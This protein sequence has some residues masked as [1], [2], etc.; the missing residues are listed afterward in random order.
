MDSNTKQDLIN[1]YKKD[2]NGYRKVKFNLIREGIINADDLEEIK[3]IIKDLEDKKKKNIRIT[4]GVGT[5]VVFASFMLL[6]AKMTKEIDVSAHDIDV[7]KY[8]HQISIAPTMQVLPNQVVEITSTPT[9]TIIPT[10]VLVEENYGF[11]EEIKNNENCTVVGKKCKQTLDRLSDEKLSV[12]VKYGEMYGIDPYLLIAQCMQESQLSTRA[13]GDNSFGIT[14]IHDSMIGT[15]VKA[16]NYNTNEYE[17]ELITD[18]KRKDLDSSVKLGTMILQERINRYKNIYMALQAYNYGE[19]MVDA[20]IDKYCSDNNIDKS[21]YFLNMNI[22][23]LTSLISDAH[24]NPLNYISKWNKKTYGD[25]K[26]VNNILDYMIEDKT[27]YMCDGEKI[28][29]DLKNGKIVSEN[30]KSVLNK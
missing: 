27:Y 9:P 14:Q 16:F 29:F 21:N 1:L 8:E 12:F 24:I 7:S 2:R 25:D 19:N 30:D 6:I 23:D 15:Y 4:I 11:D 10:P 22:D 13:Q 28:V 20:I 5:I 17:N 3:V 26:Y 18:E